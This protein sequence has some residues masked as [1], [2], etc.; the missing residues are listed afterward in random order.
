MSKLSPAS[1]L[2][3]QG[4]DHRLE[5]GPDGLSRYRVGAAPRSSIALGSCTGSSPGERVIT[6][7]ERLIDRA[8]L[9]DAAQADAVAEDHRKRLRD[10]FE[11]GPKHAL[12]WFPSG[13]DAIYGVSAL[14]QR[15]PSLVHHVVVGAS[16]L[17]GGTLPAARG[18]AFTAAPPFGSLGLG[19]DMPGLAEAC[20]AEPLHL[21]E[22]DG[23]LLELDE[24]DHDVTQRVAAAVGSG[25]RVILHLVAHSKTGL[26][27]PAA[28]HARDLLRVFGDRLW[29]MVDAAQGRLAPAD[30][31]DALSFGFLVL[32]TGSKFYSGPPF[33]G[34]VLLPPALSGD[35]GP[36]P[37]GL[38]HFST[39]ADLP[40]TWAKAR[41]SLSVASNPGLL[42]RWE[43]AL[44]EIEA[45]HSVAPHRR[46][47][48][49]HAF[50]GAVVRRM[51]ASPHLSLD[52]PLPPSH[53]LATRLGA[54]PTVFPFRVRCDDGWHDADALRDLHEYL[55]TEH[56]D[57]AG[58]P[59]HLGQPVRLGPPSPD[60]PAMLRVA[61]G[62]RL[63]TRFTHA[64][65]GG[66]PWFDDVFSELADKVER[67]VVSR[68]QR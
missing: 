6:A 63:V 2:I 8:D 45:Y 48:A 9:T 11:L 61:L 65:D 3:L 34:V 57:D 26:R 64:D 36:L 46:A 56:P 58:R 4:A 28:E 10:L 52:M 14:A 47:R 18:E 43:G 49:Y 27:A 24:V 40:L 22:G 68:G 66:A 35:P 32:F 21:R 37:P 23:S 13:T 29:V 44:A 41:A 19:D 42:A 31:R 25:R 17:G 20:T 51:G 54:Y 38:G 5:L 60:A 16:E 59:I 53:R 67:W 39:R 62:A 30:V 7:V 12:W 15:G 55:D 33:S 1:R 50:A